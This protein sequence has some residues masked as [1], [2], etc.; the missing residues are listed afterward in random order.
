MRFDTSLWTPVF[1][2]ISSCT[3]ADADTYTYRSYLNICCN[4]NN[5]NNNDRWQHIEFHP[6]HK[7]DTNDRHILSFASIG[8]YLRLNG[9][10]CPET[11]LSGSWCFESE[12]LVANEL[13][14]THQLRCCVIS[15]GHSCR[16]D[17][18][19]C[20]RHSSAVYDANVQIS[21]TKYFY[22]FSI[23]TN[24][25]SFGLSFF[26]RTVS[27]LPAASHSYVLYLPKWN[28]RNIIIIIWNKN[29]IYYLLSRCVDSYYN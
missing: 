9:L 12:P 27:I 23:F 29:W 16:R 24:Y 5:N 17:D 13:R 8:A 10:K 15:E 25:S 26:V 28:N 2:L 3:M 11:H 6:Y 7:L 14:N 19:F 22:G 18:A 20:S 1:Q 21:Y 4:N